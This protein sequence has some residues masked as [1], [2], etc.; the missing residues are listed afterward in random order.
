[1]ASKTVNKWE[2]YVAEIKP[3]LYRKLN[4][5]VAIDNFGDSKKTKAFRLSKNGENTNIFEKV[6]N[7]NLD[8]Q[9]F[10]NNNQRNVIHININENSNI[11]EIKNNN[12]IIWDD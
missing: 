5:Y 12:N 4:D 11:G 7:H 6:N 10:N 9:L 8:N 2:D 1:M 3:E